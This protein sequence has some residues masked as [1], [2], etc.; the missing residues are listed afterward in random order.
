[1]FLNYNITVM[2]S[3]PNEDSFLFFNIKIQCSP[4]IQLSLIYYFKSFKHKVENP[5]KY[6]KRLHVNMFM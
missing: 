5:K 6:H 2:I 3:L 1:M 4:N